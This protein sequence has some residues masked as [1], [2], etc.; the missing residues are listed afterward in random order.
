MIYVKT[1]FDSADPSK[2]WLTA[3][4][5]AKIQSTQLCNAKE[6]DSALKILINVGEKVTKKVTEHFLPVAEED[7]DP[8][9]KLQDNY[10]S[11]NFRRIMAQYHIYFMGYTDADAMLRNLLKEELEA[12]SLMKPSDDEDSKP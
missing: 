12:I 9:K 4:K 10:Y 7:A 5:A 11:F 3:V 6:Y 2:F 8:V 1:F